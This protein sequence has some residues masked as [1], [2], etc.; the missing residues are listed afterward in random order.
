[1]ISSQYGKSKAQ[2]IASTSA[3]VGIVYR[4][5]YE[6]A[7]GF[8]VV[9]RRTM[10]RTS[11]CPCLDAVSA[12]SILKRLTKWIGAVVYQVCHKGVCKEVTNEYGQQVTTGELHEWFQKGGN[13][14]LIRIAEGN[15]HC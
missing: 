1:M 2:P 9:K 11:L 14:L 7:F 5:L 8:N 6:H 4:R 12:N 10:T 3:V 15:C 13:E